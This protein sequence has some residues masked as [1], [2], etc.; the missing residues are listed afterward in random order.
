MDDVLTEQLA[1]K[2]GP[3]VGDPRHGGQKK[4][5]YLKREIVWT[6]AGFE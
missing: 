2:V 6:E 1:I 4:G 5:D 3:R